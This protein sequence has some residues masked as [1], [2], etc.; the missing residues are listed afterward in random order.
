MPRTT[1]PLARTSDKSVTRLA[2][3]SGSR[4]TAASPTSPRND[5]ERE[6]ARHQILLTRA[7]PKR[8]CGR[9]SS[10]KHHDQIGHQHLELRIGVDRKRAREPD[11][12]R[13]DGGALDLPEPRGRRDGK[14]EHDHVGADAGQERGRRRGERP[15]ERGE[16][17][18][19][20]EGASGRR[21]EDRCRSRVAASRSSVTA[22]MTAPLSVWRRK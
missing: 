18:A 19:E 4:T 20:D 1:M 2:R 7:A 8:P 5:E 3:A 10:T 17:R 14:R 16:D 13:G 15:A 21:A 9:S 11:H 22:R 6:P 12:Q